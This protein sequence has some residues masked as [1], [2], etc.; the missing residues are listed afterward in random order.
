M[1]KNF[2]LSRESTPTVWFCTTCKCGPW[3][4]NEFGR[5][6]KEEHRQMLKDHTL[7]RGTMSE[8]RFTEE[9]TS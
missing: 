6:F 3:S 7:K 5:T 1:P 2:K 4:D 9:V 8:G